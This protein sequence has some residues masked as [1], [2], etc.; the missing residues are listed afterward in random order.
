M[1]IFFFPYVHYVSYVLM[2][3]MLPILAKT[4]KSNYARLIDGIKHHMTDIVPVLYQEDLIGEET[5]DRAMLLALTPAAKAMEV[6]NAM[7]ASIKNDIGKFNSLLKALRSTSALC[8][9]ADVLETQQSKS[10]EYM[11]SSLVCLSRELR[12][13]SPESMKCII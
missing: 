11:F 10:G 5:R 3:Q 2:F 7:Q 9:L 4:I 12:H 1:Q 13:G 6:V 8:Y